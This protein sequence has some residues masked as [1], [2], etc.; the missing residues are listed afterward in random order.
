MEKLTVGALAAIVIGKVFRYAVRP[1]P[2]HRAQPPPRSVIRK[3]QTTCG[4]ICG[5]GFQH[6]QMKWREFS[7]LAVYSCCIASAPSSGFDRLDLRNCSLD[8]LNFRGTRRQEHAL[9][10]DATFR[11]ISGR[12]NPPEP[13]L[14]KWTGPIEHDPQPRDHTARGKKYSMP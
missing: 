12:G 8:L 13:I 1:A 3:A 7:R 4:N 6:A 14:N 10:F 2:L 11:S 9:A 5:V